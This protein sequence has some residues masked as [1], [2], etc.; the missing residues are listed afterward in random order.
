MKSM[1]LRAD[2]SIDV[3]NRITHAA[4]PYFARFAQKPVMSLHRHYPKTIK[5]LFELALK[6]VEGKYGDEKKREIPVMMEGMTY[7]ISTVVQLLQEESKRRSS[8]ERPEI[9]DKDMSVK[10]IPE[11]DLNG[12][13]QIFH[14][15]IANLITPSHLTVGMLLEHGQ[16][17]MALEQALKLQNNQEK[18][19]GI[20]DVISWKLDR[21]LMHDAVKLFDEIPSDFDIR[22]IATKIL[23]RM[24]ERKEVERAF[25]FGTRLTD[26]RERAHAMQVIAIWLADNYQLQR[27]QALVEECLAGSHRE[28]VLSLIVNVT[29]GK[30]LF[31]EARKLA[32]SIRDRGYRQ[33]AL[34]AIVKKLMRLRRVPDAIA[35]VESLSDVIEKQETEKIVKS[36]LTSYQQDQRIK[37]MRKRMGPL[38][39]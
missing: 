15:Y 5:L 30:N 25:E 26:Q 39:I 1:I 8:V 27:A 10:L 35:F 19:K 29:V 38:L 13:L 20:A 23:N 37:A 9:F 28:Y 6:I 17:K 18:G 3:Y 7:P 32:F 31:D 34:N 24:L 36:A 14:E 4:K 21:N 22:L 33:D 2:D 11:E 16:E 12:L